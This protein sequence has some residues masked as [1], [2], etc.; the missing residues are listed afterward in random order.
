MRGLI[1]LALTAGLGG[2]AAAETI[3]ARLPDGRRLAFE[4]RG[5]GRPTVLFEAGWGADRGAWRGVMRELGGRPRACAYDRAGEGDSSLAPAPRDA[6]AIARDLAQGLAAA[7]IAGPF[8]LVGH[9]AGALYLRRFAADRPESVAG[10]IFLDPTPDGAGEGLGGIV[11]RAE[12]CLAAA[13]AGA[14]PSPDPALRACGRPE[15]AA[16]RWAARLA[17][18]RWLASGP[19]VPPLPPAL[20]AVP[21]RVLSAGA[22]RDG[23][24]WA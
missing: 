3:M 4:C 20:E 1:T 22:G 12:V 16:R 2:T 7:G 14:L 10:L 19:S 8:L 6:E 23:P 11:R 17:E 5:K 24:A 13:D 21:L 18:I 9:S 15:G